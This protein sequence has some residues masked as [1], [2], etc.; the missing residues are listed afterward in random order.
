M[1]ITKD[2]RQMMVR[3]SW[4]LLLATVLCISCTS[5]SDL[6]ENRIPR[7]RP[8]EETCPPNRIV[9]SEENSEEEYCTLGEELWLAAP[10]YSEGD[11][12]PYSDEAEGE[13]LQGR[14][15]ELEEKHEGTL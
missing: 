6:S 14:I 5:P 15:E 13:D 8:D 9:P 12:F 1:K 3:I 7:D 2:Q 10:Y 4:V 11:D